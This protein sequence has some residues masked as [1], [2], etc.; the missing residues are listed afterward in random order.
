MEIIPMTKRIDR[1]LMIGRHHEQ[2]M[3]LIIEVSVKSLRA[4]MVL[5]KQ[6]QPKFGDS[7]SNVSH[8]KPLMFI[9]ILLLSG[10]EGQMDAT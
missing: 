6:T 8:L 2:A 1:A 3:G 7:P 9:A 5:I 10:P 4:Q